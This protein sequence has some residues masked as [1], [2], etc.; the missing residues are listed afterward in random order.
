MTFHLTAPD[1]DFLD[2]LALEFAA[3]VPADVPAR[4]VG[5]NPVPGT[6]PYMVARYIPG[7]AVVSHP[8]SVLP[9]M[10]GSRRAGRIAE[11][12]RLERS[13][14]AS[15]VRR[16]RSRRGRADWTD[17]PLPDVAG[18]RASVPGR[19]HVSPLPAIVYTAFNTRVA[20]V[21]RPPGA[22]GVQHR[23]EPEPPR[24]A[25]RAGRMTR[26]RPARSCLR[27]F[28]AIGAYCPFTA[29]PVTAGAWTGPNLTAARKLVAA[30]GTRGMR[31][32]VWSDTQ[33]PDEVTGPFTVSVLNELGYR[34]RLHIAS[35][36]GRRQRD[37]R[38]APPDPGDGR[39]LAGRLSVGIGLL[40]RL[41]PLF[42]VPP[43]RPRRDAK[44][45]V[46]L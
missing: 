46:L 34:A 25:P 1:P 20:A 24:R 33:P 21:R 16:P 19:V 7:H 43:G 29:H 26:A 22:A 5:T 27:A 8:Q 13:G 18:L 23:R 40:R 44:R 38:L 3:P 42:S 17:D 12:H 41:L 4:D 32:T 36:P 15:L 45:C 11:S 39:R 14:P 2:E 10:V 9:G 35:H 6:G 30:S 37:E 28:R 31:V